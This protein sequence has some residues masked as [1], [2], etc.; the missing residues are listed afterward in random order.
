M[1]CPGKRLLVHALQLEEG[2]RAGVTGNF[3]F[4][5]GSRPAAPAQELVKEL[6]AVEATPAMAANLRSQGGIK[7]MQFPV[8]WACD[9]LNHVTYT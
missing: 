4:P 8:R 7:E 5:P 9:L 3:D 2:S 6:D 1:A